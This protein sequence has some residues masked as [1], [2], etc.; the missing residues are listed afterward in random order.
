MLHHDIMVAMDFFAASNSY[1][2][3]NQYC[4]N[5]LKNLTVRGL[6]NSLKS[7]HLVVN[8]SKGSGNY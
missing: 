2:F 7:L 5:L 8:K 6:M 1:A 3:F 4:S